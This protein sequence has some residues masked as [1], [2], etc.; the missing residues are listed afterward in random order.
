MRRKVYVLGAVAAVLAAVLV[1]T[2]A[3]A[4][5]RP[6]RLFPRNSFWYAD[7]T[8]L[9]VHPSSDDWIATM[10]ADRNAHPDFGSGRWNGGPIGI[11][12]TKV[13]RNQSRSR[14]SFL[15]ASE[16]DRQ[17]YPIPDNPRIEG[18]PNATGDR[19]VLLH[20]KSRCRLFEL[21]DVDRDT[22]GRWTAGSGV[23]WNLRSNQLRPDGWTSADASGLPMM[24]GLVRYR[25]VARGEI[26][27]VIRMTAP[28]TRRDHVWP[29]THDAGSTDSLD[30]PPMGA[31]L[32]LGDH[33][34]PADFPPQARV[35]VEALQTHGA[36]IVDNGS[37]FYL[38][39]APSSQWDNDDLRTLRTLT[40]SD[41]EFVQS[42]LMMAAADSMRV[43]PAYRPG[44]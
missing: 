11:P 35:V 5:D 13:G 39:G 37:A 42:D 17:R 24:P 12:V 44:S 26:T 29:A 8:E 33:I 31:W 4:A 10:G 34:D 14:V 6:C 27:H 22:N 25:E 38:S 1:P 36:I 2:T 7:V 20:Q 9:P 16:S 28:V 3:G 32:R 21:F 15:Y 41:F 23:K 18:G 43:R 30:A 40:G 19:H